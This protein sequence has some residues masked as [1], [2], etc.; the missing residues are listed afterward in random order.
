MTCDAFCGAL[1]RV[2]AAGGDM[3]PRP[4]L[5]HLAYARLDGTMKRYEMA[6]V[7]G[8]EG[9]LRCAANDKLEAFGATARLVPQMVPFVLIG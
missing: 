2:I 4:H 9:N 1:W 5:D 8:L 6:G 7:I 3:I